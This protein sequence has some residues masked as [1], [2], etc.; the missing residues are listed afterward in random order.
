MTKR[1]PQRVIFAISHPQKLE[2]HQDFRTS[3][4]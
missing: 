2:L 4:P 1:L 3:S